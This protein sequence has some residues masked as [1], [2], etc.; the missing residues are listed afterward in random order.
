MLSSIKQIYDKKSV[1]YNYVYLLIVMNYYLYCQLKYRMHLYGKSI[2]DVVSE[3]DKNVISDFLYDYW[4]HSY[5][6]NA[7]RDENDV[8]FT[9]DNIIRVNENISKFLESNAG[10]SEEV[11]EKFSEKINML[12]SKLQDNKL[13]FISRNIYIFG[14]VARN[15]F[16]A[17]SDID[18]LLLLPDDYKMSAI[19]KIAIDDMRDDVGYPKVDITIRRKSVF[20]E[21]YKEFKKFVE[22][23]MFLFK[24]W[25]ML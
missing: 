16:N 18:L 25:R 21:N 6:G 17:E 7:V 4:S 1:D 22:K 8:L 20:D 2:E 10:V 11:L 23:D 13:E 9:L 24:E 14:S 15:N 19:E 3:K 5:P 12:Q